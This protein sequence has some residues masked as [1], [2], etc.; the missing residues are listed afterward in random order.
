M[1]DQFDCTTADKQDA[2]E[3]DADFD[4]WISVSVLDVVYSGLLSI[5]ATYDTS[6]IAIDFI[7][8]AIL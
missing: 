1:C 7:V 6:P 3:K 5:I 2:T 4:A 8:I